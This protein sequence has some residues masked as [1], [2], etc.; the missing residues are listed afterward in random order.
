MATYR[1]PKVVLPIF[2]PLVYPTEESPTETV[3]LVLGGYTFSALYEYPQPNPNTDLIFAKWETIASSADC[4]VLYLPEGNI[5]DDTDKGYVYLTESGSPPNDGSAFVTRGLFLNYV[6]VACSADGT[7]GVTSGTTGSQSNKIIRWTSNSG[8][9]WNNSGVT[10]NF[11]NFACSSSGLIMYGASQTFIYKSTDGGSSW[12]TLGS[13][14]NRNWGGVACVPD[15]SIVYGCVG[16]NF[17]ATTGYVYKSTDGGSN[18]TQLSSPLTVYSSIS[19]DSTGQIVIAGARAGAV[20]RLFVSTNGGSS[21]TTTALTGD[22]N[23]VKCS[24]DG[25]KLFA[26]SYSANGELYYSLDLGVTWTDTGIFREWTGVT[27]NTDGTIVYA[28]DNTN[29]TT[30]G[31]VWRGFPFYTTA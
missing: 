2:N 21:W 10:A 3:P 20:G 28:V 16:S 5:Y 30:G 26:C 27:C 18:W 1:A 31:N 4:S 13:A 25:T 12:A 24:P 9:T 22:Y 14:G 19:C 11:T 23:G 15:G 29:S 17:G 8:V 6:G 7:R